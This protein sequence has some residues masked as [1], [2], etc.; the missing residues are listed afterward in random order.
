MNAWCFYSSLTFFIMKTSIELNNEILE[1]I[2]IINADFPE[3]IK[4]I[5]EMPVKNYLISDSKISNENLNLFNDTLE[6]LWKKYFFNLKKHTPINIHFI[7]K[8]I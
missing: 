7:T 6:S 2:R 1:N 5:D 3:L 4:Y 8:K